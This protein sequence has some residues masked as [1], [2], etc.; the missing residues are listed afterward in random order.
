[1]SAMI[2]PHRLLLYKSSTEVWL[3]IIQISRSAFHSATDF[4]IALINAYPIECEIVRIVRGLWNCRRN[5][6]YW[7]ELGMSECEQINVI[8]FLV[9]T[10]IRII[11]KLGFSKPT[12]TAVSIFEFEHVPGYYA[13]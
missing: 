2:G 5:I 1:M 6:D 8:T 11:C 9:H 4:N 12:G 13:Q 7:Y 10:P 3:H